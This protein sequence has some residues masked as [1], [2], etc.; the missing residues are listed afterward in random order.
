M[1][2]EQLLKMGFHTVFHQAWIHTEFVFGIVQ[3]LVD[4]DGQPLTGP[5]LDRP[6]Q[7]LV[8]GFLEPARWTH[9]IQ[10]LVGTAIGM[11]QDRAVGLEHDHPDG[12]GQMGTQPTLV[13]HRASSDD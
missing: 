2:G 13:V 5:I 6:G 9:P 7:L 1:F 4:A 10:R 8:M 3:D 11:N 12:L